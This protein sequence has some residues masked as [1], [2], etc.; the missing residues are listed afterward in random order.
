[1]RKIINKKHQKYMVVD[2][3][4]FCT[5]GGIVCKDAADDLSLVLTSYFDDIIFGGVNIF[6]KYEIPEEYRKIIINLTSKEKFYT[7][8][9]NGEEVLTK[10]PFII[11]REKAG[12]GITYRGIQKS[13]KYGLVGCAF[14]NHRDYSEKVECANANLYDVVK[15]Y[16][17]LRDNGLLKKYVSCLMELMSL[18]RFN[19]NY[20]YN[21]ELFDKNFNLD[22]VVDVITKKKHIK[23]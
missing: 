4:K 7:K 14:Y 19:C 9:I 21:D 5:I 11:E 10:I 3:S 20:L 8:C 23:K 17:D 22:S 6:D 1:M 16:R 18:V 2:A 15:F 13:Y 12:Y